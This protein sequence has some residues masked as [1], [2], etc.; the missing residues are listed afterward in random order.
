MCRDRN[1]A[2]AEVKL[3]T[4]YASESLSVQ[5]MTFAFELDNYIVIDN[6]LAIELY[7]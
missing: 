1:V 2:L 7:L 3:R 6:D 4:A 5:R